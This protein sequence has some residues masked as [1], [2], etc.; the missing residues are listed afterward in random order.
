[1][2]LFYWLRGLATTFPERKDC[3]RGRDRDADGLLGESAGR[4][5]NFPISLSLWPLGAPL[6]GLGRQTLQLRRLGRA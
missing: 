4:A 6:R 1:M 3:Y 5:A 2:D